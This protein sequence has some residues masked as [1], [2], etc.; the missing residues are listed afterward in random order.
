MKSTEKQLRKAVVELNEVLGLSP[1]INPKA[2]LEVLV[3]GITSACKLI[4]EDDEFSEA[5]LEVIAEFK[6]PA[7]K[8]APAPKGKKQPE[9]EPEP[10]PVEDDDEE[11]D[12]DEEEN[13]E[14][15]AEEEEE[16]EEEEPVVEEKPLKVVKTPKAAPAKAEKAAPAKNGKE[17]KAAKSD[18]PK[19][20]KM[21][22]SYIVRYE[23]CKNPDITDQELM[24][25]VTEKGFSFTPI[26]ITVRRKEMVDAMNFL[27]AMGKLQ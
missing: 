13:D 9:P 27:R 11:E 7:K 4:T 16:E 24:K 14:Q 6:A 5:T 12:E 21:N 18:V 10:E 25:I 20:K 2:K 8:A 22:V 1:E 3:K 19:E 26:S 17:T 15:E 23:T